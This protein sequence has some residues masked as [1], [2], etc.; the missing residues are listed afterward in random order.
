[1][2]VMLFQSVEQAQCQR[3]QITDINTWSRAFAIF[4]ASLVSGTKMDEM[5]GVVAHLYL[6]TQ[7]HKDFR[8][9]KWLKYDQV[10]R[11]GR[12]LRKF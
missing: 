8:G 1:M 12:W 2:V 7:M 3:R 5:I 9:S 10:T 6:V 11:S 4:M